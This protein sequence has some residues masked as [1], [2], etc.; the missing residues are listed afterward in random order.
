MSDPVPPPATVAGMQAQKKG[1]SCWTIGCGGCLVMLLLMIGAGVYINWQIRKNF[2]VEPFE[3]L[4]VE[5]AERVEMDAKLEEMKQLQSEAEAS[6]E[7]WIPAEGLRLT[8]Q[9]VNYWLSQ[10]ESDLQDSVRIDFEPDEISAELRVGDE[11]SIRRLKLSAR[12]SV[13]EGPDGLDVRIV[14]VKLGSFS[15]PE[16][17]LK[18]LA[19]ENLAED[20]IDDPEVQEQLK[21][22]VGGVEVLK[23]AILLLPPAQN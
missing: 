19:S 13:K 18:E 2:L 20:A 21:E 17:I 10:E 11:G 8:E 9:E 3:P 16:E 23:D 14:D 5:E 6:G 12:I 4:E 7:N 1:P 22:S 15:L